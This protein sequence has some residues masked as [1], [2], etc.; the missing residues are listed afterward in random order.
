MKMIHVLLILFHIYIYILTRNWLLLI[1]TTVDNSKLN[2]K[3]TRRI[4]HYNDVIMSAKAS[5]ITSL[6]IV[7]STVYSGTDQ[8]K[9]QR[10]ASRSL[11][12]PVNS[13]HKGPVT[14]KRFQLMTSSCWPMHMRRMHMAIHLCGFAPRIY[15]YWQQAHRGGDMDT[16]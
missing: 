3:P 7:H 13:A 10:P 11:L 8:R 14:R 1:F 16:W 6:T 9:H 12:S 4:L 5:Q 2:E 15:H